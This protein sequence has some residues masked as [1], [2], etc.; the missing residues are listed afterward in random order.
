MTETET[1]INPDSQTSITIGRTFMYPINTLP[2][3]ETDTSF[4]DP[5]NNER[6]KKF[7]IYRKSLFNCCVFI[8]I[9][10]HCII[11]YP[12]DHFSLFTVFYTFGLWISAIMIYYNKIY[13][14]SLLILLLLT[15]EAYYGVIGITEYYIPDEED[16]FRKLVGLSILRHFMHIIVL[17]IITLQ[18][19]C[20]YKLGDE[21]LFKKYLN[22]KFQLIID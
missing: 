6:F 3:N 19:I 7:L 18:N 12:F 4:A 11:M 21:I 22:G 1:Q 15:I 17:C 2:V 20:Y 9:L 10:F 5:D 14:Y 13:H 16:Y 8:L